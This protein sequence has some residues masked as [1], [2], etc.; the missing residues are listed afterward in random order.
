MD[1]LQTKKKPRNYAFEY[2]V[3][4][5]KTGD[6]KSQWEK[7]EN[8]VTI[9]M[10]SLLEPDGSK[11]V[12]EYIADNLHGFRA[13]VKKIPIYPQQMPIVYTAG[14]GAVSNENEKSDLNDNNDKEDTH[15]AI[16]SKNNESVDDDG[17]IEHENQEEGPINKETEEVDT[18][19]R[20][21][22]EESED[23]G[24]NDD[25]HENENNAEDEDS[26]TYS[27]YKS[28]NDDEEEDD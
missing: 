21:N 3:S 14:Y 27:N 7:R 12:V 13:L 17:E 23:S 4:D 20:E 5:P 8:G 18:H 24:Y 28:N 2:G 25:D 9:G 1:S 19:R 22:D 15:E 26:F 10:Y 11:R 6:H 16:V